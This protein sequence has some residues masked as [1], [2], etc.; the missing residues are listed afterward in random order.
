[1]TN[2][3]LTFVLVMAAVSASLSQPFKQLVFEGGGMR[4]ISF[5]GAISELEK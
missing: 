1:M 3:H 4:G 5:A 2:R